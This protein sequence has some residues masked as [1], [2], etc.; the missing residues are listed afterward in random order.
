[1][2]TTSLRILFTVAIL[3]GLAAAPGAQTFTWQA[4]R[5]YDAEQ[6]AARVVEQARRTVER[7]LRAAERAFE[8]RMR[9]ADRIAEQARR[10]AERH[11]QTIERQVRARVQAQ[12]RSQVRSEITSNRGRFYSYSRSAENAGAEMQVGSDADPCRDNDRGDRDYERHCEVRESTLPA[13]ALNV[14][15]GQNGGVSIEGWDRNEIRVRAIVQAQ[16]R[17][18]ADARS[19]AG[20]VQV[21]AGGG[22]VYS[23]G[24]ENGRREWWSV[25]Y[26]I[27][28]PRNNDLDLRASNGGITVVG[29]S[30][31][32]RFDT[33]NG[34]V[35]LQ[36]VGGRVNGATRN[37]GLNVTLSGSRWEGEGLDVETSNGGV[38]LSIPDGYNAELETRTV[39]G[40]L[41]ID[42]PITVQGELT[43]R[44]GLSTTLGSGGPL[45]RVRTTNG[46]VTIRR[47]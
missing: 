4:G 2:K 15:A 35:K 44:R 19:L 6:R 47:R 5:S 45:V 23:T 18:A 12:I 9:N 27:N 24:P 7:N 3:V 46:G 8:L 37:G 17:E 33:T 20:Q 31:N 43:G 29:V 16:A 21:Q 34:G 39:N 1:M 42:F 11:A 28:V 13:G 14:D 26:R 36:D 32:V 41:R 30:G 10:N 40:G 22:R 25:S 38:N